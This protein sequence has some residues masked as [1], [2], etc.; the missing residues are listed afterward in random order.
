MSSPMLIKLKQ[1]SKVEKII[2]VFE[3]TILKSRL[4]RN[5]KPVNWQL[6]DSSLTSPLPM[7]SKPKTF[8]E[9]P[10]S[11]KFTNM[12]SSP[13]SPSGCKLRLS[14]QFSPIKFETQN[15]VNIWVFQVF[16]KAKLNF[17]FS[18]CYSLKDTLYLS[19]NDDSTFEFPESSDEK[20]K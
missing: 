2:K 3:K 7:I 16:I 18:F 14:K 19:A 6:N 1:K 12:T 8:L 15:E 13:K 5:I 4:S 10:S 11:K 9:V 17:F 20:H